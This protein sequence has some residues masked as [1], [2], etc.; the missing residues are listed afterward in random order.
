MKNRTVS[1]L[2]E[3]GKIL[4][5][6][7][8]YKSFYS[9]HRLKKRCHGQEIYKFRGICELGFHFELLYRTNGV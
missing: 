8:F 7:L 2:Y 3:S 9:R 4:K 1:E 6:D 5:G